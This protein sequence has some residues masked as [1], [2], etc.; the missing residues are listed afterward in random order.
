MSTISDTLAK[1]PAESLFAWFRSML[2]TQPV[3]QSPE[4]GWQ[5]FGYADISRILADTS[6]FSSDTARAF[7][8]PQP[9]LDFFDMGNLVTTDPPRHRQLRSVISSVFTARAVTGLTPRIEKV[10]NTLLDG[11]DG[12]DRF[13]L[14]D[15][16][17]YALPITVILE[18]LGLPVEDEPLFRVWGEALG[19]VDAAT[20][21]PDRLQNEVVP[22]VREMNAY[23]LEHVRRLRRNPTDDVL[24][25]LAGAKVDGTYLDDG[26]IVGVTGLTMFAGHATTM[27]LI[28]NAVLLF[29]RHPDVGAAVRTDRSLLPGALEE[30]LRLRPPFPRL[31]R[32]TTAD[33]ELSGHAIPAGSLVTPWVGAANRD[34]SRFPDPDRFD[35]HRTT[36]HLVFG[37]GVHFCLGAPLARLEAKIALDIL[38]DRYRDIAVDETGS[39]EFENPRQLISPTRLP[40]RVSG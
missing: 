3:Y 13:D 1:D 35:I 23:L 29:D 19:T 18:L 16:L 7:N 32:I 30:V 5:V 4:E 10:T 25:R 21:P 39:L 28:G 12:A 33:T 9:D 15:S 38:M 2:D 40:V 27:A 36:S 22:A 14:I 6:T 8:P 37:Q 20:V 31:A 34:G 11:V 24:S 26:E 17:A